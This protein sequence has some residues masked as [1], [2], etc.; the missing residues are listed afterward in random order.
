MKD[1]CLASRGQAKAQ[2]AA[3]ISHL[4][5]D[6]TTLLH[7]LAQVAAPCTKQKTVR[8]PLLFCTSRDIKPK[9]R[10]KHCIKEYFADNGVC[11]AYAAMRLFRAQAQ[12]AAH[13]PA[14]FCKQHRRVYVYRS[15]KL[16]SLWRKNCL[17][18]RSTNGHLRSMRKRR[19]G[20]L[21]L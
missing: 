20:S 2:N 8:Y 6:I 7:A 21:H 13:A 17:F 18:P 14:S 12:P 5:Q 15:S 11:F 10:K 19:H 9:W 16:R 3:H 1:T 4:K